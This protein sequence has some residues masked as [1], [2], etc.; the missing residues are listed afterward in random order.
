[1]IGSLVAEELYDRVVPIVVVD[2][3]GLGTG[4]IVAGGIAAGGIAAGEIAVRTGDR[5]RIDGAV[6]TIES[7]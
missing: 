5:V 3:G 7:R 4:G 6:L 1:T 2:T